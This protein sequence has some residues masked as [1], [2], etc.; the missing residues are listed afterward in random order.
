MEPSDD[1][2]KL[3]IDMNTPRRLLFG[4]LSSF[5]LAVGFAHAADRLDPMTHSLRTSPGSILTD[6]PTPPCTW[7]CM[8]QN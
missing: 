2:V 5:L 7:P 4:L 1:A 3:C 6:G 8:D